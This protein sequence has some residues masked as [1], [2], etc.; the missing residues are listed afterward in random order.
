MNV[1]VHVKGKWP[2]NRARRS[3]KPVGLKCLIPLFICCKLKAVV[4]AVGSAVRGRVRTKSSVS[5]NEISHHKLPDETQSERVR[6]GRY[7]GRAGGRCSCC[8]HCR[9]SYCCRRWLL[10]MHV[11]GPHKRPMLPELLAV[12]LSLP[13]THFAAHKV[14]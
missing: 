14:Q 7:V 8:S 1:A 6:F 12:S 13:S 4:V 9:S 5:I 10:T 11:H 3:Q 2:A